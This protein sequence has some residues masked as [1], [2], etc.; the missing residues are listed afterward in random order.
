MKEYP[1]YFIMDLMRDKDGNQ[2]YNIIAAL[3][4]EESVFLNNINFSVIHLLS[5]RANYEDSP[6]AKVLLTHVLNTTT[7][8]ERTMIF[9]YQFGKYKFQYVFEEDS[10]SDDDEDPFYV[11]P[12][13]TFQKMKFVEYQYECFDNLILPGSRYLYGNGHN[14]FAPCHKAEVKTET[15]RV[16]YTHNYVPKMC[17]Y[18]SSKEYFEI[19]THSFLWM[20]C[21]IEKLAY[22]P[23]RIQTYCKENPDN[24]IELKGGGHKNVLL[25]GRNIQNTKVITADALNTYDVLNAESLLLSE[26]SVEIIENLLK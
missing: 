18:S 4:L 15:A 23:P 10:D 7:I 5:V 14:I 21:S 17:R 1:T 13:Y 20:D 22:I 24:M 6:H 12:E 19:Y 11:N 8:D 3:I 16:C 9:V 2:M 26:S 25:S